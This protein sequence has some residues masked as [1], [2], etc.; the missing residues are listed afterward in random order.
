M[1]G[2]FTMTKTP[3]VISI[4]AVTGGGKTTVTKLLEKH[5]NKSIAFCFDDYEYTKQPGNIGTWVNNGA[6]PKEWDLTLIKND[7]NDAIQSGCFDFI[8]IDY[9]FG[10]KPGYGIKSLIDTAFFIDTPADIALARRL[11]RDYNTGCTEDIIAELKTYLSSRDLFIFNEEDKK[12]YDYIIDGSKSVEEIL[13]SVK[14][15]IEM[16]A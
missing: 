1:D 4:S 5:L 2:K 7:I 8:I 14:Q 15:K 10:K 12:D 3:Y 9:P 16:R 13:M 6:D 11:I